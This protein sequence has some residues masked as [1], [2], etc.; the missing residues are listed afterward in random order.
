MIY[1]FSCEKCGYTHNCEIRISDYDYAKNNQKC[2]KCG[3]KMTRVFERFDG[4]ISLSS[5]MYGI[6]GNGG[7]TA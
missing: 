7:W 6:D 4:G 1:K 5:G 3:G 2:P